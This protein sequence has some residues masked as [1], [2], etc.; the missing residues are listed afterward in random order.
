MGDPA[1]RA[2]VNLGGFLAIRGE[3]GDE[4]EQRQVSFRQ[5]AGLSMPVVHFGIYI[6]RP[7]G[8]PRW[9]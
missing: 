1:A 9:T 8:A 5:I 6:E 2:V 4:F 3:I 7:I